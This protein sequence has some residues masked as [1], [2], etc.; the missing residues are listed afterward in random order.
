MDLSYLTDNL[1]F[2]F[3]LLVCRVGGVLMFAPG[4]SE[5]YVSA[6]SRLALAL[7]VSFILYPLMQSQLPVA[8]PEIFRNFLYL[9]AEITIGLYIGLYIRVMQAILHIVGMVIA[10]MT[11][12][13]S[14]MLFDAN[15]STQGSVIGGF[16][17]LVGITLFFASG[18]HKYIIQG[19][20]YSYT[21][22]PVGG[23]PPMADFANS[24]GKIIN[25]S[26]LVAFQISAPVIVV[27][28]LLYLTAGL[29][30]RLMPAMQ[31]FFVIL[32]LQIYIGFLFVALS[33]SAMFI[34][35]IN[36]YEDKLKIFVPH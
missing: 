6:R 17:T 28:T 18:L 8:H 30:G 15:Q 32:P 9:L 35:Y 10:F 34:A 13:S 31:V 2:Q 36:F 14:A 1:I 21:L 27:C 24:F 5:A 25:D 29:M 22:F 19:I 12:L 7:C 3:A 23:V 4:F 33:F 16:L 26:F 11:G 20:Y